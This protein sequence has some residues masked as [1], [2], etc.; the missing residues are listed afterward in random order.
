MTTYSEI[1]GKAESVLKECEYSYFRVQ[2]QQIHC[3]DKE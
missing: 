1:S 3:W 2:A